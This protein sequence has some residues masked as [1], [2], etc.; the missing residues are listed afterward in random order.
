MCVCVEQ[1]QNQGHFVERRGDKPASLMQRNMWST[2][3]ETRERP[4]A[5]VDRC[6][7]SMRERT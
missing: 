5:S 7:D 6:Q 1:K 2:T 4:A 3:I